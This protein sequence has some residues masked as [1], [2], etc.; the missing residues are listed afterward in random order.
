MYS[1]K[2]FTT[3]TSL[4]DFVQPSYWAFDAS[5]SIGHPDGLWKLAL[6]ANN[7]TDE[8]WATS[9]GDRPFLPVGGDD[10]IVN[11]NRGRQIFLQGSVKF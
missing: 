8:I 10:V 3:Q 9:T 11:Q 1:D 6:I 5:A 2:Y 7:V 4:T